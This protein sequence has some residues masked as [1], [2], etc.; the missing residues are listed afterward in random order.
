MELDL[1]AV[2]AFVA[3]AE[4]RYFSEA[5]IRLDMS[6][7]AVS[8]RVAKLETDL[9]V[10]LLSRTRGG[11]EPTEDGEE[12]LKHARALISLA[13]QAVERLQG[14]RRPLRVDVL[15][16]RLATMEVIRAFHAGHDDELELVTPGLGAVRR[17]VLPESVDAAFAR[18]STAPALGIGRTPA[19][20]EPA[21]LL[22]GR[23]HPLARRRRVAM[24]EL[25]GLTAWMPYNARASEWAEFWAELCPAF[26]ILVDTDG[27]NFG[28][29]HH[30]EVLSGSKDRLGFVGA[31]MHVPWHPDVVQ[32][33]LVDPTPVYPFSLLWRHE[34]RHPTLPR[35]IEHVRSTYRPFDPERQWL[36]V[37][38]REAMTRVHDARGT[39]G[40]EK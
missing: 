2:R 3:V 35:L 34:N 15:G 17:S 40:T 30:I 29:E 19:Y 20:L 27:P 33:P 31:K 38:D 16:T 18:A 22:V 32:I 28:L 5:A 14:R 8:K 26:G 23:R 37:S 25:E 10:R 9:G 7:Q 39:L 4:D 1:G 36:P 24:A 11:A 12:F 21:N 6:Q 13:D